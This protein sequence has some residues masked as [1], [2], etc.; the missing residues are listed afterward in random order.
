MIRKAVFSY[1]N[2]DESFGNTGGFVKFSDLIFTTA[3]AIRCASR[4]FKEVQFVSNDWGIDLF[5]QFDLPITD[6]SN[7]LNKLSGVKDVVRY[8][9]AYGKMLAYAMQDKPFIHLDNDVLLWGP[10]PPKILNARLCFQSQ[11]PFNEEGYQYYNILR[12]CWNNAPLR[13]KSITDNE[14]NDFAYN[15]GIC[16]GHNLDFFKEWLAVSREYIF[17]LENHKVIFEDYKHLLI[18]H[19]LWSEQYFGA[20]LIKKNNLRDKV[21]ILC[22]DAMDIESKYRYTHLWGTLKKQIDVMSF[23]RLRMIER[24]IELYKRIDDFCKKNNI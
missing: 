22:K 9:W 21:K 8:F 1:Y 6:Y 2:P 7:K 12:E 5:R 18:H 11:E 17:A 19:N 14:V 16:G 23:V 10:L 3:L 15:C 4:H 13:P 24:N 20:C